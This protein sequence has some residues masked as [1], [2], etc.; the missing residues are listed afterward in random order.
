MARIVIP[1]F[2][3]FLIFFAMSPS[4]FGL[5][6]SFPSSLALAIPARTRSPIKSIG[7][8]NPLFLEIRTVNRVMGSA[9]PPDSAKDSVIGNPV[10]VSLLMCIIYV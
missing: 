2:R 6:T 7:I 8:I 3:S 4:I 9:A 10:E 5:L 1:F